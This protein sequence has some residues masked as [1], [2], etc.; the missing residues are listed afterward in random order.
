MFF[1]LF[2]PF[3]R[4][5]P[6]YILPRSTTYLQIKCGQLR[7]VPVIITVRKSLR[8][9]CSYSSGCSA[10]MGNGLMLTGFTVNHCCLINWVGSGSESDLRRRRVVICMGFWSCPLRYLCLSS[11]YF[12]RPGNTSVTDVK[13]KS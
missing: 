5:F 13:K 8:K 7:Q 11:Q 6:W 2:F 10:P 3:S 9:S 4:W 12:S 1:K